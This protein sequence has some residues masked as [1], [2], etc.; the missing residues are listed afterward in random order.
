MSDEKIHL[1]GVAS[2]MHERPMD[3]WIKKLTEDSLKKNKVNRRKFL[4]G[5]GKIAG[6]SLGLTIAQSLGSSEVNAVCR[7]M[8]TVLQI[9]KI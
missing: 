3:E 1:K 7:N 9:D 6:I 2:N 4:T 5:A 8:N